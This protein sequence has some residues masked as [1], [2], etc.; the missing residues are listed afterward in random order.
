MKTLSLITID[1]IVI[2]FL[3]IPLF[4][5]LIERWKTTCSFQSI[6]FI[7]SETIILFVGGLNMFILI[8]G[9]IRYIRNKKIIDDETLQFNS[10]KIWHHLINFNLL[11]TILIIVPIYKEELKVLKRTLYSIKKIDYPSE[12]IT[13]VIGDDGKRNEIREFVLSKY[14]NYKYHVRQNIFGHAKAGN[15]NDILFAS[16]NK[17]LHSEDD[18]M[19][20]G[21][22][23][24]ILDCDMAPLP[25]ILSNLLPMFYNEETY[26][27][28]LQCC[29]IQSPQKFCNIFGIDFLG[30]HYYFFYKIVLKAYSGYNMVPCC[31]TNV[32]FDRNHLMNIDGMQ[33]GSITEDFNTSL[34]L[35]SLGLYS[36]YFEKTTAIGFS[37]ISLYDFY[38]QRERWAIGGLQ[39]VLCKKYWSRFIK[40]PHIYKWIY[41]FSGLSPLLSFFLLILICQPFLNISWNNYLFCGLSQW[42]YLRHFLP[43]AIIYIVCLLM[44]QKDLSWFLFILNMQETIFMIPFNILFTFNFILRTIGFRELTFKITPKKVINKN[45]IDEILPTISLLLP[46]FLL[47][48][49]TFYFLYYTLRFKSDPINLFWIVYIGL[50]LFNPILFVIQQFFY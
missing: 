32:L 9:T 42:D 13:V 47:L 10:E 48:S 31:G 20:Q 25:D 5:Y 6:F 8:T 50:Q 16:K 46:Y 3:F 33:Y 43:Y 30:Q 49:L 27:R 41:T 29:F 12:L 23:V 2:S 1:I 15:V 40:L 22:Y 11:P 18:L 28:N 17:M 14:P 24:L 36:K 44:L 7:I 21:E 38:N 45:F 34:K 37:P 19:Y 4:Y 26:E 39:I 35:H